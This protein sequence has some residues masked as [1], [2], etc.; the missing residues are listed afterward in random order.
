MIVG[1]I[2]CSSA[3]AS[4]M[5][6]IVLPTGAAASYFKLIPAPRT[7]STSASTVARDAK[8]FRSGLAP[9]SGQKCTIASRIVMRRQLPCDQSISC[10]PHFVF[11]PPV[12][13]FTACSIAPCVVSRMPR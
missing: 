13:S 2:K 5:E 11:V 9:A 10:S 12:T 7:R 3:T 1:C 8:S 6:A 4:K